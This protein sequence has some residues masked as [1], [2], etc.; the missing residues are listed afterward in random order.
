[1]L[2]NFELVHILRIY[3][4]FFVSK[5]MLSMWHI[6][7]MEWKVFSQVILQ[8]L[9]SICIVIVKSFKETHN[10]YTKYFRPKSLKV[11]YTVQNIDSTAQS[12]HHRSP[13]SAT[14][15]S[16]QTDDSSSSTNSTSDCNLV[17]AG[18]LMDSSISQNVAKLGS[19]ADVSIDQ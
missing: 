4:D 14:P 2:C 6:E 11:T 3:K 17:L 5:N 8:L 9:L 13:F 7:T 15:P 10:K 1:M 19:L 16:S 18:G 12:H